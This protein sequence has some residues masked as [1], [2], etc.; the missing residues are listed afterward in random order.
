MPTFSYVAD[1][2]NSRIFANTMNRDDQVKYSLEMA[3]TGPRRTPIDIIRYGVVYTKPRLSLPAGVTDQS[4]A[5]KTTDTVR[6]SVSGDYSTCEELF[7][8]VDQAVALFKAGKIAASNRFLLGMNAEP[9]YTN[10]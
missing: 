8:R 6:I 3:T 2:A 9:G 5:Q 4:L 1:A 7:T 10:A